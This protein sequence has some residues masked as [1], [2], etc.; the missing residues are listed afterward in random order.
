[1]VIKINNQFYRSFNSSFDSFTI[2]WKE[3]DSKTQITRIF[4][5]D[6]NF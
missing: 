6:P 2:V 3:V 4:L 5:S 1:M